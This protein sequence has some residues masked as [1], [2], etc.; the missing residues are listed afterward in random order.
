MA[1]AVVIGSLIIAGDGGISVEDAELVFEAQV[2][3][4]GE[5]ALDARKRGGDISLDPDQVPDVLTLA[6][7][8][9]C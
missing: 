4:G 5:Q 7:G 8:D 1:A 9:A 6:A 3:V 2:A